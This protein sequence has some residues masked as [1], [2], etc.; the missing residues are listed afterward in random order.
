MDI[1]ELVVVG[2]D[3][4]VLSTSFV[5]LCIVCDDH[6]VPAVEVFI[7]QFQVP[8]EVAGKPLYP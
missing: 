7:V 6:L 1:N 8:E 5:S 2:V 3:I 4:L